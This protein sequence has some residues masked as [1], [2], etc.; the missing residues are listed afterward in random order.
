[1]LPK[2]SSRWAH[3]LA[4]A[5]I[6]LLLM[7]TPA[8]GQ[9]GNDS[10]ASAVPQGPELLQ[11]LNQTLNWNRGLGTE[12]QIATEASDA[13][14]VNDN[15]NIADR[16]VRLAFQFARAEAADLAKQ[17]STEGT[18]NPNSA[19]SQ[20]QSLMQ[21]SAKLDT[22][23]KELQA[24]LE[25]ARKSMENA[26]GRKRR[27]LESLVAE[28]QSELELAQVRRDA[29]HSMSD[30]VTGAS[31][32]GLGAS[33]LRSQVEAMARSLPTELS[34]PENSNSDSN[35]SAGQHLNSDSVLPGTRAQPSGIWGLVSDL[36]RLSAK[37]RTIEDR[38]AQTDAL[39]QSSRTLRAPLVSRLKQLSQQG[40]AIA[41]QANSSDASQLSKQK[42]SLDALTAQFK[43]LSNAVV[44]LG[45][46]GILLGVYK[47]SLA[48]WQSTVKV[49]YRADLR[50]LL[51][52]LSFLAIVLG[53]VFGLGEVWRRTI[54]RYVHDPRRR[55]QFLLL[56]KIVLWCSIALVVAFAFASQIGSVATFAGLITAGVAV[57]LQNVI[58]SIAGYFFLIGRFGIR[59]GDRV[60][61]AGVT[62]EVVD[63][64]L[65]RLHL[66]E[67]GSGG[68]NSP[69]GR[70][71][72]FS[73]SIVFQPTAGIFKQIP[74]T[75]FV[76]HEVSLQLPAESDYHEIAERLQSAVETVFAD[77]RDELDKQRRY[78]EKTLSTASVTELR[79]RHRLRVAANVVEVVIRYPVDFQHANE[80][81]DR[82]T[83]ELLR[84][85]GKEPSLRVQ[86]KGAPSLT[87]TTD[88]AAPVSNKG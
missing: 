80:I 70:I 42:Q 13:I 17:S 4:L 69:S 20:Y 63:I 44:P 30:F 5:T 14:V 65:V 19:A 1:M 67:L 6:S 16:V 72:A 48:N 38:I 28:T 68:A 55:Y 81:D 36:I 73:N 53:F 74:G 54:V 66:M 33:G 79:P 8:L 78:M 27:D 62:G 86:G 26:T 37:N 32:S 18:A 22:R 29:I 34:Q 59:V 11:F 24:E 52:R 40:D 71:V 3:I 10:G 83:R 57:A 12:R 49:E 58:L 50:G 56:R 21:L 87:V 2:T 41:V 9:T 43:Q 23:V 82:V 15:R 25:A 64:G 31:A 46:Q 51:I 75:N 88:V 7:V 84:A 47:T 85:M 60:Q 35:S 45:K 76:W 61:I 77:Y 39:I